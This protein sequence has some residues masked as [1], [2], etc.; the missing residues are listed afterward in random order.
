MKTTL[1]SKEQMTSTDN[2]EWILAGDAG[3]G[4]LYL[5][6]LAA[7]KSAAEAMK[8]LSTDGGQPV[9]L[10]LFNTRLV[11]HQS[12]PLA[13]PDGSLSLQTLFKI[14][15]FPTNPDG[16]HV[17]L[18]AT[19]IIDVEGDAATKEMLM[20]SLKDCASMEQAEKARRSKIT[21]IPLVIPGRS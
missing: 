14:M 20:A 7:G 21:S 13:M 19:T 18:K 2:R 17:C 8:Q 4:S 10:E 16:A 9:S 5:G 15:P 3:L 1:E 12:V 6:Q 11:L